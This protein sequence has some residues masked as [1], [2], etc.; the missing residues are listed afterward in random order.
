[1]VEKELPL[2][3]TA[4]QDLLKWRKKNICPQGQRSTNLSPQPHKLLALSLIVLK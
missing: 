3:K 2:N 4:L 1:M